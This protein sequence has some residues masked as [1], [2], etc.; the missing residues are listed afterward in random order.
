MTHP[1]GSERAKL[2]V[3]RIN[4]RFY[5]LVEKH[6]RLEPENCCWLHSDA[7]ESYC[8]EHA[9]E[10]RAKEFGLGIPLDRPWY[11]R[12]PLED[13]FFEEIGSYS[14]GESDNT[15]A[16]TKCGKTL[17]YI[18]TDYGVQSELALTVES[19]L[20]ELGEESMYLLDRLCLNVWHDMP[21]RQLLDTAI[22]VGHAY[23]QSNKDNPHAD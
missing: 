14:D 9:I 1:K 16:C 18:L 7:A 5:E 13:A 4:E 11:S 8:W 12:T 2:I 23:R 6:P 15:E 19:P 22:V 3:N 20:N 21:R 10:A 17:S